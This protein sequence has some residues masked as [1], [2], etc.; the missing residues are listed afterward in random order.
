MR[1]FSIALGTAVLIVPAIARADDVK[2]KPIIDARLRYET[3]EQNGPA[4]VTS[5]REANGVTVRLRAGSELTLGHFSVLGEA[6]GTLAINSDYNAFPFAITSSQRRTQ[7]PV[8]ADPE[9]IDLN[10]LQ[11]QYQSKAV[12]ATLGR[13]R[14]NIDDQ[15]FVGSVGWRQNEQTFDA[16]RIEAKLGPVALDGAYAISQRTIFGIDADARQ[17]LGGDF[18]FLGAV[19]QP[20]KVLTVKSFAYIL[21]YDENFAFGSSSQT[22]GGRL[23]ARVPITKAVKWTFVS[24]YARQSDYG[25]NPRQYSTNYVLLENVLDFKQFKLTTGYELLGSDS[26]ANT[27]FQTPAA[28]L[29]KFNGWADI[30]LNTPATGIQ[31]YYA[32]IGYTLPAVGK[33]GPL[34]ASFVFHRFDSDRNSIHYGNE[35]DAQISLKLNK[36][37]TALIKYADYQRTGISSFASDVSTRK[38]WAQVDFIF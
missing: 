37:L 27:A 19:V 16:A 31:D 1:K 30:F 10:R 13:Q 12:T 24:S 23:T 8:I 38:F 14:I 29:H 3:V 36:H 11:I 5:D 15:R 25:Q 6:E 35:Y 33:A 28:T 2:F 21:D 9:N 4:P 7:Y 18:I 26:G 34:V 20:S 32:G 17:A 22:Y